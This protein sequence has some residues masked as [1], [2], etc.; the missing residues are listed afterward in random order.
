MIQ[1]LSV[2]V[3]WHDNKWNGKICS[4]PK[5]NN[6]CRILKNIAL[7]KHEN[8]ICQT[9]KN[10][11]VSSNSQAP[12]TR[13]SGMFMSDHE[14]ELVSQH[15]YTFDSHYKHIQETTHHNTPFSFLGIPYRWLLK[16]N[17]KETDNEKNIH[18][19]HITQY[20]PQ[21]EKVKTSWISNG[22]NQKN[23]FEYFYKDIVPQESMV[24]AYAKAIPFIETPGRILIALG[25]ILNISSLSEYSYTEKPDNENRLSAYL[26]ERNIEHSIRENRENGFIFPFKEIENYLKENPQQNPEELVVI[27][28]FDFYDE[29][30]YAT[31]HLSH[32]TLIYTLNKTIQV[33]KKY[34]EINLPCG[35]GASWQ[36]CI[37]W[38]EKKL[39]EIWIDRGIY[40]GLGTIFCALNLP[41][42]YDIAYA[43]KK[44]YNDKELWNNITDE[45]SNIKELLPKIKIKQSQVKDACFELKE[46]LDYYKLL[47]R[48]NLSL[49]QAQLLL[50]SNIPDYQKNYIN[51]LTDILYKDNEETIMDNPYLLHEKT[52]M[53]KEQYKISIH[54]I[55]IAMFAPEYIQNLY[56]NDNILFIDE[57]EDERRLRAI[58]LSV[59]EEE[60]Q[61]G[62][63]LMLLTDVI[64]TINNFRMDLPNIEQT[65]QASTFKRL[66]DVFS[67][68]FTQID[69]TIF[70][71][72]ITQKATALQLNRLITNKELINTILKSKL[73]KKL[74]LTDNW[75]QNLQQILHSEN[76]EE[77]FDE[78]ITAMKK[79][80]SSPISILTGGAGT[81]KTT[82]IAALCLNQQIQD[83][84]ILILAPTGKARTV[85]SNKLSKENI[86]H[87]AKTVFQYLLETN[88]CNTNTWS[89]YLSGKKDCNVPETVII[90]ESSMLTEEMFGALIEATQQAKRI[91]LIGDHNQLPP[92]GTGKPFYELTQKLKQQENQPHYSC[93]TVS[94]RQKAKDSKP[95]V[96]VMLSKLFTEDMQNQVDDNIFSNQNSDNFEYIYCNNTEKLKDVLL[97]TLKKIKINDPDTFNQSLGGIIENN[98]MN[99]HDSSKIESWQIL[100]PYKNKEIIGSR[101]INSILQELFIKQASENTTCQRKSTSIPLGTDE[102][103]YGEKVINTINHSA[104]YRLKNQTKQNKSII[105][106][107]ELGLVINLYKNKTENK[108]IHGHI[109]E[110]TSQNDRTFYFNSGI[111]EDCPFELAY[112][113]TVHKVQGSGFKNTIFVLI[114]PE[115]G[116]N[117]FVTREML[118]TALTRQEEK[119]FLIYN[120]PFTEL[121]K[122]ASIEFSDLAQ[123]KTNL[124]T[125]LKLQG[126]PETEN[127]T[128]TFYEI[129]SKWYDENLIHR[130]KDG[131]FVRSKSEVI[132]YNELITNHIDFTYE[133]KL[134]LTNQNTLLPDFTIETT[135]GTIYWEHLGMLTDLDYKKRWE[136]KKELYNQNGISE[137]NKNLIVTYD[138]IY[139]G[140]DSEKIVKIIQE[141][142]L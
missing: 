122:Y 68:V 91:I 37:N 47:A 130:T 112:A 4:Y 102:I 134:T 99:Y 33:L 18:N 69:V 32:D 96:D 17:E 7:A 11:S 115:K 56:S 50:N 34:I 3:P 141:K 138:N 77:D 86:P 21:I 2:R 113:L 80:A 43:I 135:N 76:L 101:A 29:Y 46:K 39:E 73:E 55:D 45:L 142:L 48:I 62:N 60:T 88:H 38:C 94:N 42:G 20:N 66:N 133:K 19:L 13:E 129:K 63:S 137:E 89:F 90:D 49:P 87:T 59:L 64:S 1:H 54:Q 23:I 75:K 65:V 116:A 27:I 53:L 136:H 109:I 24:V 117:P 85:L 131:C 5:Y 97:D 123:R 127:L 119:I 120:K 36:D 70:S 92:I 132:I 8:D 26:W 22:I 84:R 10:C 100:S 103:Y 57:P 93:L 31:E 125:E 114:E 83:G 61:K 67:A 79:M 25:H 108:L 78:K 41:Y 110:F 16:P 40:P 30:S 58:T 140:I 51:Q 44:K 71:D 118:Y 14:I 139:G 52:Y 12:C 82:T 104:Q 35:A 126:L 111:S 72:S 128:P 107:G 81:G 124:F 98:W 106:N 28:P 121:K 95:R 6:S 105:S 74:S 9:N 15:P